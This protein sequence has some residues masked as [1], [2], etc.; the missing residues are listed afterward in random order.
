MLRS[1]LLFKVKVSNDSSMLS[2]SFTLVDL[3]RLPKYNLQFFYSSNAS[4]I[5]GNENALPLIDIVENVPLVKI[6]IS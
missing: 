5:D 4:L 3:S 1:V 6:C 2:N